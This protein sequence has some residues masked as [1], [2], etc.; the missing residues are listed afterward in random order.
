S[1]ERRAGLPFKIAAAQLAESF[2]IQLCR[3]YLK[4]RGCSIYFAAE[5]FPKCIGSSAQVYLHDL[6]LA[7]ADPALPLVLQES[8]EG[9]QQRERHYEE[10]GVGLPL[11][12]D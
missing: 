8:Q 11:C 1:W 12:S 5:L 4:G 2:V 10:Q 7:G 6:A 9:K 3:L